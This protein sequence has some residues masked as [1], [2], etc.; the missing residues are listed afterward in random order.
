ME[1]T[2]NNKQMCVCICVFV[3]DNDGSIRFV[4]IVSN[5]GVAVRLY[6]TININHP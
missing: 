1:S 4:F 6:E 3:D 5:T 2:N